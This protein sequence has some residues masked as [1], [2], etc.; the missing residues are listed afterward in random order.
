MRV[1]RLWRTLSYIP[2]ERWVARIYC[3]GHFQL[4]SLL[5]TL[6]QWYLEFKARRLPTPLAALG[7]NEHLLA[8]AK[9]IAALNAALYPPQAG[10]FSGCYDFL[11]RQVDFGAPEKV[12]WRLE[13]GEGNNRLWRMSLAYFGHAVPHLATGKR[14][15]WEK[16]LQLLET[17]ERQTAFTEPGVLPGLWRDVWH[18][19]S[20]SMR[21]INLLA[22]WALYRQ[23]HGVTNAA[24]EDFLARHLCRCAAFIVQHLEY[25]LGYNHL[26]KN[27]VAL[28]CFSAALARPLWPWLSYS[29][30]AQL[31]KDILADGGHCERSPMYHLLGLIDVIILQKSGCYSAAWQV[32]LQIAHDKMQAA[33]ALMTHND[34]DIA[35]FNDAWRGGAP[36]ARPWLAADPPLG[37]RLLPHTGYVRLATEQASL[38][39]DVGAIGP[40]DNPGHAHADYL[41]LELCLMGQRLII[42]PGVPTYSA[43]RLRDLSRSAGWHNGPHFKGIEPAECWSSFRVGR[44]GRAASLPLP[45]LPDDPPLSHAGWQDGYRPWQGYVARWVGMWPGRGI[46][47]ADVWFGAAPYQASSRFL[48][49]ADWLLSRP[50]KG[51]STPLLGR[52]RHGGQTF[53]L[54]P[55]LGQ[56]APLEPALVWP[57]FGVERPAN[58]LSLSPWQD[59][60]WR[61]GVMWLSLTEGQAQSC[62]WPEQR[63]LQL[64][65]RLKACLVDVL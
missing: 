38:I 41:A 61:V 28:T 7:P 33:L 53:S 42:D 2:F 31:A 56:F 35:L 21:L 47:L 11:G 48:L 52:H 8:L 17:L 26:F 51:P 6:A 58:A 14:E 29:V 22:G 46:L 23:A 13:M 39:M 40:D 65:E 50:E 37:L 4:F 20:V 34:G 45:Y 10:W 18:P 62:P 15:A 3:R 24:Q 25:D 59:G 5:P 1:L 64:L 60:A 12:N 36:H 19:Y 16:T 57:H 54:T 9:P 27:Y 32:P 30:P 49:D 44:R 43:G 63:Y 55:I